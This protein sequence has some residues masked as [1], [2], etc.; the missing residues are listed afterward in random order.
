M[1]ETTPAAAPPRRADVLPADLG[2]AIKGPTALGSDPR[3]LWQLTKTMAVTDFKLRFFGSVLGYLWQ[4]MR[5]LMLFGVLFL[6]FTEVVHLG[7]GV[8]FYAVALLL[9]I[10]LYNFFSESTGVAVRSLVERENLVRKIEFPRLA[11]PAS[12]VLTSLFNLALNLV[13]VFVFL[14]AT[15]GSV[16]LSW[17]ELPFIVLFLGLFV[18]GLAMLLSV[19]YLRYRDV[20]PIWDVVLQAAF[21]ASPIFVPVQTITGAHADTIRTL[22]MM[23][24]F[25]AALQQARHAVIDPSHPT[26][27]AAAGGWPQLMVPIAIVAI[28]FVVGF[29]VFSREAPRIAER[30]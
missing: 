21:Y 13:P 9:G 6:V 18:S 11:V 8:R 7:N 15:G 2:H 25:A 22:L 26:A 5:P 3:R 20:Q 23:N 29:R 4:L 30:L 10:V 28:A 17:L 16:R 27:L 19:A 12:V 14:L 1:T 24:P